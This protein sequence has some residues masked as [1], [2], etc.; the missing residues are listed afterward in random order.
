MTYCRWAR[1]CI[2][3]CTVRANENEIWSIHGGVP[4]DTAPCRT[5]MCG[6]QGNP[7]PCTEQQ[8]ITKVIAER[9]P[10]FDV[11]SHPILTGLT[12]TRGY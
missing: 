1:V 5:D 9:T 7:A 2:G 10:L 6:T 8:A 12:H 3:L 4:W 11:S